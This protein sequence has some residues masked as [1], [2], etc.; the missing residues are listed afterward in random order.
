MGILQ[1]GF[2][3][4]HW[5]QSDNCVQPSLNYYCGW[6]EILIYYSWRDFYLNYNTQL[7]TFLRWKWLWFLY[8][9]KV[10]WKELPEPAVWSQDSPCGCCE[11]Q[12]D[13]IKRLKSSNFLLISTNPKGALSI[14]IN[15]YSFCITNTDEHFGYSQLP[16]WRREEEIC[17]GEALHSLPGQLQC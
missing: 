6:Q 3:R 11:K 9:W 13:F 15:S 5:C 8:L 10:Q 2:K 4:C 17:K 12:L 16:S 7:R 14:F 1:I